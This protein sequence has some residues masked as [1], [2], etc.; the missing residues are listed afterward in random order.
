MCNFSGNSAGSP[1]EIREWKTSIN[2][3]GEK[4]ADLVPTKV[5]FQYYF[6]KVP[7]G[8]PQPG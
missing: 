4:K 8:S 2:S 7:S 5:E 3:R 1:Q 6:E